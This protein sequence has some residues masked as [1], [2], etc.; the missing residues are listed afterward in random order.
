MGVAL[1]PRCLV[2]DE[3]A[4][5]LVDEPLPGGGYRGDQGY[6]FCYPEGRG[7][8]ATLDHFR[9]WLLADADRSAE[10]QAPPVLA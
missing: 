8:L 3:I 9:R 1:V 7:Q 5:G 6:W 2:Q 10:E 4:S